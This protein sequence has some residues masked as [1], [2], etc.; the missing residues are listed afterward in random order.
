MCFLTLH[1]WIDKTYDDSNRLMH[2]SQ[3]IHA[4]HIQ[5]EERSDLF[6]VAEA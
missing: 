6:A 4:M 5:I 2:G 1:A 3:F